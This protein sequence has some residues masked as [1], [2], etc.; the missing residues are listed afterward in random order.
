MVS[1]S[2]TPSRDGTL[3][4]RYIATTSTLKESLKTTSCS[5]MAV[6][7]KDEDMLRS[8]LVQLLLSCL[9][10]ESKMNEVWEKMCAVL[11]KHPRA[12]SHK[13]YEVSNVRMHEDVHF[14]NVALTSIS[15]LG[16][17]DYFMPR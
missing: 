4:A 6:F 2:A 1:N 14:D 11:K 17:T 9:H 10:N 16:T 15:C 7:F 8:Q 5:P 13:E 3:A 12:F